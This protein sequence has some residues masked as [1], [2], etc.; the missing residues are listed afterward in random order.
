LSGEV[1][2]RPRSRRLRTGG[3]GY[4]FGAVDELT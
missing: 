3:G 1:E 2:A 4:Q